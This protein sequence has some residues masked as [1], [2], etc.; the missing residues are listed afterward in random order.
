MGSQR[1]CDPRSLFAASDSE[2]LSVHARHMKE[3][4]KGLPKFFPFSVLGYE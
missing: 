1:S 4:G 3:M 2:V